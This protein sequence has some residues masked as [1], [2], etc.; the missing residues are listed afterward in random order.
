[1]TREN[2]LYCRKCRTE[3]IHGREKLHYAPSEWNWIY[4][5]YVCGFISKMFKAGAGTS[6]GKVKVQKDIVAVAL[7][8]VGQ[9][10]D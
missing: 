6:D 9:T 7:A 5:C 4:R 3:T 10:D 2:R 8:P 1:M